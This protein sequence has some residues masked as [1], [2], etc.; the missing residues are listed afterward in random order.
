MRYLIGKQGNAMKDQLGITGL[1]LVAAGIPLHAETAALHLDGILRVKELSMDQARVVVVSNGG[2][3]HV[4]TEGLA[5]FSLQIDL[6]RSYLI[7]FERP[8]CISKQLLFN[9]TVPDDCVHEGGFYFPFQVTLEPAMHGER[10]RFAGPVGYVRFDM[11]K[12][13]FGYSTDYRIAKDEQLVA[14]LEEVRSSLAENAQ[15]GSAPLSAVPLTDGAQQQ[16]GPGGNANAMGSTAPTLSQVPPM[17]HVLETVCNTTINRL[18]PRMPEVACQIADPALLQPASA[19]G[20]T[21]PAWLRQSEAP[22]AGAKVVRKQVDAEKLRVVTTV[23]VEDHGRAEEF[24]RVASYYGG[25]TYF[26]RSSPC[27]EFTFNQATK[28]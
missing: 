26:C 25:V 2:Y 28:P 18:L 19:I 17:V 10:V 23:L 24:K 27:S 12:E 9:T 1:M 3:R 16:S 8:G 13:D 4:I 14:Q 7:S 22:E 15:E 6:Q 20:P 21:E 11:D 5:H